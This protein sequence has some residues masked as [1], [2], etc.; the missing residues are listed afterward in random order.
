MEDFAHVFNDLC[1]LQTDSLFFFFKRAHVL[2]LFTAVISFLG[3]INI[4]TFPQTLDSKFPRT[5]GIDLRCQNTEQPRAA[6]LL[7]YNR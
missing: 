3:G 4:T 1:F 5:N 2:F 7:A 6:L